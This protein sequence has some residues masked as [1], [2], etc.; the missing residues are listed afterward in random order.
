MYNFVKLDAKMSVIVH[1]GVEP[2]AEE[3]DIESIAK[4]SVAFRATTMALR[5]GDELAKQQVYTQL[6]LA[7][8]DYKAALR[9]YLSKKIDRRQMEKRIHTIYTAFV[10]KEENT[11]SFKQQVLDLIGKYLD[12]LQTSFKK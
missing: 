12:H 9:E 8:Q 3:P 1:V 11:T 7:S 5:G 2:E 4:D 10:S 6:I